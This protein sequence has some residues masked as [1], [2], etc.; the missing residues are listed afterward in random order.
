MC[1]IHRCWGALSPVKDRTTEG[2][3]ASRESS[4]DLTT[5]PGSPPSSWIWL[6][7]ATCLVYFPLNEMTVSS[8]T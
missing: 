2:S 5:H 6:W 4:E 8:V 3:F 1:Q 7:R